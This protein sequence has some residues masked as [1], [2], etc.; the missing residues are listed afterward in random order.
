MSVAPRRIMK[1]NTKLIALGAIGALGAAAYGVARAIRHRKQESFDIDSLF[2]SSDLDDPV[3]VSE[4]VVVITE[5]PLS[6]DAPL[7]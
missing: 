3:I 5:A 1:N 7:R 6:P 4:E 2:D